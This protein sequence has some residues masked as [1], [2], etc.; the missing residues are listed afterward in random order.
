MDRHLIPRGLDRS[1]LPRFLL[2]LLPWV[3]LSVWGGVRR[4]SN[5]SATASTTPTWTTAS[6]SACGSSS[7]WRSSRWAPA[8][9]SWAS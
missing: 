6:P 8:P 9:S 5:C 4:D 7:T 2:W 1:D 3:A